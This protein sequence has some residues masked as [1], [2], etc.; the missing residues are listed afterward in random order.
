MMSS[1]LFSFI[2]C[3]FGVFFPLSNYYLIEGHEDLCACFILSFMVLALTFGSLI[4]FELIFVH[5]VIYSLVT[6]CCN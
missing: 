3:A 4:H 1:L 5:A 6:Q 2:A